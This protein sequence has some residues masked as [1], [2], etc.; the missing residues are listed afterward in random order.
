M[1][2][3]NS[4]TDSTWLRYEDVQIV[5]KIILCNTYIFLLK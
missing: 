4:G 1:R 3:C 5:D 2:Q